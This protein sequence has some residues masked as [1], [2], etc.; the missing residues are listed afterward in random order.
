[1]KVLIIRFSSIG[2][3]VLTTPVIRAIAQQ[4]DFEVHFLTK[5]RFASVLHHNPYI[6]KLY[7]IKEKLDEVLTYL[8]KEQ[9]S[10]LIDLHK[11]LRSFRLR[12]ALNVPA[13]HFPKY[14]IEKWLLVNFKVDKLPDS[15]IVDRYFQ[16]TAPLSVKNDEKGLDFFLGTVDQVD[17]PRQIQDEGYLVFVLGAAHFTKQIPIEL[18]KRLIPSLKRSIF[19]IGGGD[20]RKV[21]EDLAQLFP[22]RV[23]NYAGELTIGQSAYLLSS[24]QAVLTPD[25][26][27]M[28]IAAAFHRPIVV[29][30]GNTTPKLGMFPYQTAHENMEVPNLACRPCDKIGK[31]ACPK[32]HFKCMKSQSVEK[33]LATLY[34][35]LD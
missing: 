34:R 21:G 32:G 1:M 7:T 5:A 15:H 22:E 12:R 4:T 20:E 23:K 11:N 13:Y 30:W 10:Y 14:N 8:K 6:S 31:K 17:I 27:M 25:T 2:D 33:I 26:G 3:V 19:L 35:I 18:F 28:H 16:A 24:A 9:Y 29:V